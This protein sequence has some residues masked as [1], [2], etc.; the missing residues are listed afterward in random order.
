MRLRLLTRPQAAVALFFIVALAAGPALT[1]SPPSNPEGLKARVDAAADALGGMPKFKRMSA[2][3]REQLAEFVVGN[4][5]F[6][7]LHELGHTSTNQLNLPILGRKEDAADSFAVTRLIKLNNGFSDGVL[8]E[9]GM[10]WFLS[11][12]AGK[13]TGNSVP[14]YDEHG[15]DEQRGYEIV[16]L[17]IGSGESKYQYL[18]D[19]THLPPVRQKTCAGDYKDAA[20]SWDDVLK[21]HLRAPDQPQQKIDVVYGEP[22]ADMKASGDALRS[23]M[24]L[25]TVRDRV[26]DVIAWPN[27]FTFELKTCGVPNAIWVPETLKLTMCYELAADFADTY[28]DYGGDALQ[29]KT[30]KAT[31]AKR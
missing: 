3:E 21:P 9:A 15:L 20:N 26:M 22:S 14:F 17:M 5:L 24:L 19:L 23:V 7:M 10:G 28:R 1:Q 4:V 2:K 12:K 18:A 30:R 11:A 6:A 16:C 29:A 25:E 13:K 31:K 8:V 27:P